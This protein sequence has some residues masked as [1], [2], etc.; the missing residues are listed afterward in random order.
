MTLKQDKRWA[1]FK[2]Q[3]LL[4]HIRNYRMVAIR[5]QRKESGF[6]VARGAGIDFK[7]YY[8]YEKKQKDPLRVNHQWRTSVVK[9]CDYWSCEPEDLFPEAAAR[10]TDRQPGSAELCLSSYA[11]RQ[12][13]PESLDEDII[14]KE[15][16]RLLDSAY[17]K[18]TSHEKMV[19]DKYV[20][21]C[22]STPD[23]VKKYNVTCTTVHNWVGAALRRLYWY[24]RGRNRRHTTLAN[25]LGRS[26]EW[27]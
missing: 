24:A 12:A 3:A 10:H 25:F 6:E 26:R 19:I 23:M 4:S 7:V 8:L 18:L 16:M 22:V 27:K 13:T 5:A 15:H 1:C 14:D 17:S 9:L 11:Q 2:H 21:G 20:L